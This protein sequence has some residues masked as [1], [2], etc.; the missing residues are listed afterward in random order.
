MRYRVVVFVLL[1]LLGLSASV[2][3]QAQYYN[4]YQKWEVAPFVGYETGG[5]YPITSSLTVDNLR[6]NSGASYGTYVDYSL[7]SNTQAEFMWSR[8]NTSFSAHDFTTGT[9]SKAFDSDFDQFTFG[10]L[11][12][13][14]SSESKLR[15]F[16]TGGIGF[17]HESNDNGEPNHTLL[18]FVLGG[19]VK[20]DWTKHIGFRGDVRWMP[21]R[22]NSTPGQVCTFFGCY[23]Q[24]MSNYLERVNFT[25]GISFR[26]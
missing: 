23:V 16:A 5:S 9:Y 11:Y 10:L 18:A 13:F 25:G 14:R 6:I 2:P 17:A 7:T 8:N 22:A 19:G 12:K 4:E 24:N 15:P 1:I 20:Y 26:F 3:A 21:S